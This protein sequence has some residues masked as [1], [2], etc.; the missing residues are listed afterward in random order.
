MQQSFVLFPIYANNI[1]F[2]TKIQGSSK[3]GPNNAIYMLIE[4]LKP[5]TYTKY[6]KMF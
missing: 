3:R 2:Y 4:K 5:L 1:Y 6:T